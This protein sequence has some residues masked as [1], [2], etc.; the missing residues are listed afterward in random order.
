[1]VG[2]YINHGGRRKKNWPQLIM[3]LTFQVHLYLKALENNCTTRSSKH[4]ININAKQGYR[5]EGG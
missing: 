2:P 4:S 5:G 1:M 3:K